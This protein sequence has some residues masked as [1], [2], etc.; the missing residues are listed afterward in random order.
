MTCLRSTVR[1]IFLGNLPHTASAGQDPTDMISN[2]GPYSQDINFATC[3]GFLGDPNYFVI[4]AAA[5]A[6]L[7]AAHTGQAIPSTGLYAGRNLGDNIARGYITVDTVSA[8]YPFLPNQPGY[9]VSGGSGIATNQN[10]L[11]GEYTWSISRG[12][13]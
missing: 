8:C 13:S 12:T 5:L 10:T 11:L 6:D 3:S 2:K 4:P 9:F 1:D 7:Q